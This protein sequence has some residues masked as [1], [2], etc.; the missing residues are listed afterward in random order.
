[1]AAVMAVLFLIT[2]VIFALSQALGVSGSDSIDNQRQRDSVA[3][4]FLAESG[5]ERGQGILY[6]SPALTSST[7]TGI[8]GGP[9]SPGSG[10]GT[11][12]LTATSYPDPCDNTT[13]TLCTSC[14]LQAT[15]TM[16]SASRTIKRSMGLT[17]VNGVACNAATAVPD[18]TNQTASDTPPI[19]LPTWS[20][21][22][23]NTYANT[24]IALFN[25]ATTRQGNPNNQICTATGC[26]LVWNVN[27]SNGINS[28]GDMGNAVTI[29][30]GE[31]HLIY[32][33]L[34]AT[35]FN[36][37][38]VGALFPGNAVGG[39][40]QVGAFWGD[41]NPNNDPRT[42]PKPPTASIGT[43]T[44]G[45]QTDSSV[46][47][48]T[49]VT[50]PSYQLCTNWCYGADTLVFGG[51]AHTTDALN[52]QFGTVTFNTASTATVPQNVR[53]TRLAKFPSPLVSGAPTD[54]F[55]EVWYVHNPDYLYGAQTTGSIAANVAGA[56]FTA[57]TS[58]GSATLTVTAIAMGSLSVGD[59]IIGTGIPA[60]T[61]LNAQVT[62]TP[63]STGTY[64]LS[65]NASATGA[66]V[67]MTATRTV[68][69]VT[70]INSGT[71]GV[72]QTLYSASSGTNVTP[73]TTIVA[74]GTGAGGTGTYYLSTSQTVAAR[75]ITSGA[76]SSGTT[77]STPGGSA[78]PASGTIVAVRSGNGL[79]N[80][81]AVVQPGATSTSFTVAMAPTAPAACQAQYTV[82]HPNAIITNLSGAQV[83]GG[84]CALFDQVPQT[85]FTEFDVGR[86]A[87]TVAWAGG[88]VCLKGADITPI[89]VQSSTVT[90]G[91]WTEVVN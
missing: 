59:T 62:G 47:C 9:Y 48:T 72:G 52:D 41:T 26:S 31:S 38:E 70:A 15:G 51:G 28:V 53:L 42:V 20:L 39:P 84:T 8:A 14:L 45:T 44:N 40:Q 90:G 65:A 56:T 86:S 66:G 12:T 1:M 57:S 49:T 46:V 68:L 4:L 36:I 24:A 73:G 54:V 82:S 61:K 10:N 80:C 64:T 71:L 21:N 75:T 16:G 55:S 2:A 77:V 37:A 69:T 78:A 32:Q 11:F 18:C 63:G 74:R 87:N 33:K 5:M 23:K 83:C 67:S 58:S 76:T 22:L 43:V 27:A 7:C 89:P 25:L 50:E 13:A 34:T 81:Q 88:F 17:T 19:V 85:N 30:A 60:G 6:S 79:F 29:L 3:A 91:F 35:G